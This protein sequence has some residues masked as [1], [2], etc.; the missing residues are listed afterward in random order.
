MLTYLCCVVFPPENMVCLL[1]HFILLLCLSG[2]FWSLLNMRDIK[3]V[4]PYDWNIKGEIE[5]TMVSRLSYWRIIHSLVFW[6]KW[7]YLKRSAQGIMV[8][9]H[10]ST[11]SEY[12]L[13]FSGNQIYQ[14]NLYRNKYYWNKSKLI[15]ERVNHMS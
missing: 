9:F 10:C 2:L 1:I 6:Q 14:S 13:S 5:K 4:K 12:C 3:K 15:S 11:R 7:D 8:S